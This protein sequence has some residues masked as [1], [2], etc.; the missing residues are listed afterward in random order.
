MSKGYKKNPD[1]K[2]SGKHKQFGMKQS[3]KKVKKCLKK[4]LI[5]VLAFLFFP[6]E[7]VVSV[8]AGFILG[9]GNAFEFLLDAITGEIE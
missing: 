1:I 7:L 6:V 9:I 2:D 8:L 5:C 3:I 4:I